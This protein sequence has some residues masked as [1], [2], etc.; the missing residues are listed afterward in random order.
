M[1]KIDK[2]QERIPR[3]LYDEHDS[4][5]EELLDKSEKCTAQVNRLRYLCIEIFKTLNQRN[6]EFMQ[7]SFETRA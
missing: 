4:S 3:F 6:P 7:S 1:D 5:Y 2:I